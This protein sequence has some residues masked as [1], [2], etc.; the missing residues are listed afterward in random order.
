MK[1]QRLMAAVVTC[2]FGLICGC[3]YPPAPTVPEAPGPP[4][5][6]Q[7]PSEALPKPESAYFYFLAAQKERRAGQPDKAI[8]HLRKAM[9]ADPD[10]AYLKRELAT[11]YLQNKEEERHSAFWRICWRKI[12][13]TSKGSS[14]RRHPSDAQQTAEALKTYERDQ[15][16][17]SQRRSTPSSWYLP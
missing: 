6:Q 7:P 1:H 16:D 2:L 17:P 9:D 14:L 12:P 3:A 5:V 11:I 13:T 15:L 10:S 4:A 8:L